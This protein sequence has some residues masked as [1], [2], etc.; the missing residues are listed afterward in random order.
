MNQCNRVGKGEKQKFKLNLHGG[1]TVPLVRGGFHSCP[2]TTSVS[3]KGE[4]K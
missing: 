4:S 2:S 1:K 3:K